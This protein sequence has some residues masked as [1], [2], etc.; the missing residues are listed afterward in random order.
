M[1][2]GTTLVPSFFSKPYAIGFQKWI[3]SEYLPPMPLK[4]DLRPYPF[5]PAAILSLEPFQDREGNA[6]RL[7]QKWEALHTP[8]PLGSVWQIHNAKVTPDDC[9]FDHGQKVDR[10]FLESGPDATA[11]LQPADAAFNDMPLPV[12]RFVEV[13]GASLMLSPLVIALRN[14]GSDAVPPQPVTNT[15][16]TVPLVAG[17]VAGTASPSDSHRRHQPFEPRRLVPLS[18]GDFGGKGQA[19]AVSNQVDL[20]PEPASRA[21]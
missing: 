17:H 1:P 7:S 4:T 3:S 9:E 12:Q 10:Q 19:S 13:Q 21:A 14:D 2:I 8:I 11:L 6:C 5:R 18:G 20:A 15:G 16:I